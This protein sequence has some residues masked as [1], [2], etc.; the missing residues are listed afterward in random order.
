MIETI[1]QQIDRAIEAAARGVLP[2]P[3]AFS[4][5]S[6]PESRMVTDWLDTDV[7]VFPSQETTVDDP[8]SVYV[9]SGELSLLM[10]ALYRR[11]IVRCSPARRDRI[12]S[13]END[14]AEVLDLYKPEGIL[15][16]VELALAG[17][18]VGVASYVTT[19]YGARI[20][21][22]GALAAYAHPLHNASRSGGGPSDPDLA[23]MAYW[24]CGSVREAA[25]RIEAWNAAG[26]RPYL[27]LPRTHQL[28]A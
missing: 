26:R 4:D 28:V 18:D 13:H 3:D 11:G 1:D 17:K 25:Q 21:I 15:Q 5:R 14:H 27:P 6:A 8:V 16:G 2:Q 19:P 23:A 20:P 12:I 24:G 9:P 7:I 10:A 22:L